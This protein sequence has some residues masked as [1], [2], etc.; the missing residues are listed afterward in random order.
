MLDKQNIRNTFR[1]LSKISNAIAL[2]YPI[3]TINNK[4][5]EIWARIDLS[6]MSIDKFDD[7]YIASMGHILDLVEIYKE[8]KIVI[9]TDTI[10]IT[11][12]QK[13]TTYNTVGKGYFEERFDS[14]FDGII[15][16]LLNREGENEFILRRED[17]EFLSKMH[18]CTGYGLHI[19]SNEEGVYAMIGY[20]KIKLSDNGNNKYEFDIDAKHLNIIPQLDYTVSIIKSKSSENFAVLMKCIDLPIDVVIFPQPKYI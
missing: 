18:E 14:V 11:E 13:T 16:S 8:P 9:D 7:C 15:E 12:N 1:S 3:T 6:K 4:Q 10:K 5:K 19:H 17:I 20:S 2:K